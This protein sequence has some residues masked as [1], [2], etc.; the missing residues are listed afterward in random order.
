[1]RYYPTI[2]LESLR[3]ASRADIVAKIQTKNLQNTSLQ[4]YCYT[5]LLGENYIKMDLGEMGCKGVD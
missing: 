1:M 5:S 4:H 2:C 3:T